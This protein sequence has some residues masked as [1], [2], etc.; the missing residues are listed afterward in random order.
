MQN[1]RPSIFNNH[2]KALNDAYIF[3]SNAIVPTVVSISVTIENKAVPNQLKEQ[4]RDLFFKFF[5]DPNDG[6]EDMTPRKSEGESGSGVIV[7]DDGYIITNNHVVEDASEIHVTTND[8]K[9]YKAK[10]IGRDP[11]TDLALIGN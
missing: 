4:W 5:G 6:E 11:S 2:I 8:R 1:I 10:L 3:A 9:E 7:S